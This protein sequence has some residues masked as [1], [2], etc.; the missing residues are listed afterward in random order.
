MSHETQNWRDYRER[1]KAFGR[2]LR[3]AREVAGLSSYEAAEKLSEAGLECTA[4]GLLDAEAGN[5]T[6]PCEPNASDLP[7]LAAVYDCSID[8]FFTG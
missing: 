1:R 4:E 2:R 5:G 3:T 7:T 6:P 8:D